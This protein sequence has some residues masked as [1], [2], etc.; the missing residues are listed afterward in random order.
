MKPTSAYPLRPLELSELACAVHFEAGA[1]YLDLI[2]VH[3]CAVASANALSNFKDRKHTGI[4]NH[5]FRVLQSFWAVDANR[6]VEDETWIAQVRV[7]FIRGRDYAL[8]SSRYESVSL[9][10]TFL[11][12]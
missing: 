7:L 5:N 1:E 11:M 2:S 12:I 4:G 8:P 9:P 3:G 6:F 10:P